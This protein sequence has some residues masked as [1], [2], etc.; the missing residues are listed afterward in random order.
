MRKC[1]RNAPY[2]FVGLNPALAIFAHTAR[3]VLIGRLQ[4]LLPGAA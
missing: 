2:Y 3:N 4:S 1:V